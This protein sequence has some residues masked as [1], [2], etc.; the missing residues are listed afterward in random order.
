MVRFLRVRF[1]LVGPWVPV[2]PLPWIALP[3]IVVL[4]ILPAASMVQVLPNLVAAVSLAVLS[5]ALSR[6]FGGYSVT[7]VL[8]VVPVVPSKVV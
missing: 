4:G 8:V 3:E 6:P 2:R 1:D 5:I 7:R